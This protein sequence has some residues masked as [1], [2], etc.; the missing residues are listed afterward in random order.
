MSDDR[1]DF[2]ALHSALDAVRRS[3]GLTWRQVA[4]EARV[5]A[6]S[7]TRMAQGSRPDID[8]VVS[9]ASWAGLDVASFFPRPRDEN[10]IS[11][12]A[13]FIYRDPNLTPDAAAALEQVLRATYSQLT[14]GSSER[15]R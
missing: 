13:A 6:S 2:D 14:N 8:T 9:L 10:P 4:R 7:L 12:A 1:F 3:R 5:S 11:M 15:Q